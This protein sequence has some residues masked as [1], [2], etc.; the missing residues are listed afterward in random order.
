MASWTIQSVADDCAA[1][2]QLEHITLCVATQARCIVVVI[3]FI[4]FFSVVVVA[5]VVTHLVD[6]LPQ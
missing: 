4:V 5:I 2:K 3:F 1:P 6:D